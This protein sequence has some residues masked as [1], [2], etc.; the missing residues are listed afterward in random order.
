VDKPSHFLRGLTNRMKSDTYLVK[1]LDLEATVAFCLQVKREID[2]RVMLLFK[3]ESQ[4]LF[5]TRNANLRKGSTEDPAAGLSVDQM[6]RITECFA[7]DELWFRDQRPGLLQK[8][9]GC[10]YGDRDDAL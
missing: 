7:E 3:D 4:N 10:V 8:Q 1:T 9:L 5:Q 2:E 6:L